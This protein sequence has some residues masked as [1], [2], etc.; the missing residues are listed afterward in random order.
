MKQQYSTSQIAG[1]IG[2]HPNTVR[3][4]EDLGL[5][6][7]PER[8]SNGYRIFT[9]LHLQQFQIARLA[10]QVEI[11]QNGLRKQAVA[12]VKTT[13]TGDFEQ[14]LYLTKAYLSQLAD[15]KE[16]AEQAI[17]I[18]EELVSLKKPSYSAI[19]LTRK[20]TAD[21]LQIT[22]DTLRNW[23]LNGLL[24][25]RRKQNGYRVYSESDLNRLI[26]IKSLRCANYSLAAILRLLNTL[27]HSPDASI[28]TAID[29]AA[30]DDIITACDHLL[31]SLSAAEQNARAIQE[32]LTNLK[33]SNSNPP[34]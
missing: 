15:E 33:N 5:I 29:N 24:T 13:A 1:I 12:I 10:F 11:L 25:V 17:R 14:A 20:E 32:H 28:R 31:T 23:E 16:N 6:S 7:K 3:L 19:S 8:K 26:I 4:Y 22:I 18:T 27:S 2:I 9:D 30:G 34:I 21:Y